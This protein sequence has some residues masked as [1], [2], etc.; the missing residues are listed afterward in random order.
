VHLLSSL[1]YE[2]ELTFRA[3]APKMS[4]TM[5]RGKHISSFFYYAAFFGLIGLFSCF[6]LTMLTHVHAPALD[7]AQHECAL[8]LLSAPSKAFVV[9]LATLPVS[10]VVCAI[11]AT[12]CRKR[13]SPLPWGRP[14]TRSPP[15]LL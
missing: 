10:L 7:H 8:C 14:S 3:G 13:L 12:T 11:V 4:L 1:A 6:A 5:R 9:P 15:F 2:G